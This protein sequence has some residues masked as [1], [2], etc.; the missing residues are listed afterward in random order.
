MSDQNIAI[1]V[2]HISKTYQIGWVDPYKSIKNSFKARINTLLA[3]QP[4]S[5][6]ETNMFVA[7]NDVSFRVNKGESLA[8]IGRNGAGKSTLLKTLAR[9]TKPTSGRIDIYGRMGALLEVGTGFNG[10]LS[11]RENIY[12]NA[13]ILGIDSQS[14]DKR[15]DEIVDFAELELFIDTPVKYYSSGMYMRLAFSVAAYLDPDILLLDEVLAVGD[16]KFQEKCMNKMDDITSQNGK[17]LLFVS[18]NMA[19]VQKMCARAI[20]LERGKVIADGPTEQVVL[21]Y[22]DSPQGVGEQNW[23]DLHAAPGDDVVRVNSI[24]IRDESGYIRSEYKT[25]EEITI[26]VD[27]WV[28]K[29]NAQVGVTVVL[30]DHKNN[31]VLSSPSNHE[32]GWHGKPRPKG[33]YRST[34]LIPGNFLPDG[35]YSITLIVWGE[36]YRLIAELPHVLKF[37]LI[38]SGD[39]RGDYFGGWEGIVRPLLD[40]ECEKIE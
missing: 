1:K 2:E 26:E 3:K 17:T 16:A 4:A 29:D 23:Q 27:H 25:R 6:S 14:I 20:L 5:T 33:L 37:L 40:W 22:L 19:A 28:I 13:A 39:V 21:Q 8:I 36:Y 11:G 30:F 34:C 15:F 24:R 10:E 18:H 35:E 7:L 9:I 31:I 12:L 32:K 38:D